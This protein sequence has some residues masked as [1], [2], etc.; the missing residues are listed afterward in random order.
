MT[1]QEKLEAIRKKCIEIIEGDIEFD[2]NLS[3]AGA[4]R[5]IIQYFRPIRLADVLLAIE[6][7]DDFGRIVLH[8]TFGEVLF[9]ARNRECAWNLRADDLTKQSESCINFL[10]SLLT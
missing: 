5:M 8:Q 4:E 6:K 2:K 7:V 3:L 10:Y 9:I 1:H